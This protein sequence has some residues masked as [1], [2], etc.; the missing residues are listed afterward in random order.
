MVCWLFRL[1]ISHTADKDEQPSDL[2]REHMCNC[3]DCSQFYKTCQSLGECL[4]REALISK[5]PTPRRLKENILNAIPSQRT[6]THK[7]V[8][9]LWIAAAAACLALIIVTAASLIV[10]NQDGR[11][12]VPPD[13]QQMNLAIQ[14]LRSVYK[15]V[16]R[17][18]PINWPQVIEKPLACEYE[19]LANDT[20]SAVRFLVACVDVDIARLDRGTLN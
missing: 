20:Q 19:R 6:K 8:I 1:M 2:I 18:L 16:G 11:K 10:M 13:P 4:T 15:Q 7:V 14:G 9:E 3:R 5:S 17:D 12:D